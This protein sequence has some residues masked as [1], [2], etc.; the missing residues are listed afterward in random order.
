[1]AIDGVKIIDSDSAHDVYN[2]IMEMYHF[3]ESLEGTSKN[4][5]FR[6]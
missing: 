4:S 2:P 1:M 5:I 3:G 6:C